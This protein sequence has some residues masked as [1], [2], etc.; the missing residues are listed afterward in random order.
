MT[1]E[2]I[3]TLI[4]RRR[5]QILIHSVIYY[6]M[7]ENLISDDQWS[8]WAVELEEL[9]RDYPELA[10]EVPLAEEFEDFDHSTGSDLPLDN[11]WANQKAR[12]LLGI[13]GK[14]DDEFR[15]KAN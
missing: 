10:S 11:E 9:Q 7:N 14:R 4:F 5:Q 6:K 2:Y 15:E 3:K 13:L 12:F 1:D 8:K